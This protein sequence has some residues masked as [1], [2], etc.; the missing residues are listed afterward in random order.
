MATKSIVC[1]KLFT[2]NITAKGWVCKWEN[3]LYP[4]LLKVATL[5]FVKVWYCHLHWI[6]CI[7]W[8][9][10]RYWC[11]APNCLD[12]D[13]FWERIWFKEVTKYFSVF[14]CL[15]FLQTKLISLTAVC[16]YFQRNGRVVSS[17]LIG[18]QCD[19]TW[20]ILIPDDC[21]G[22]F[23]QSSEGKDFISIIKK[24]LSCVSW[25]VWDHNHI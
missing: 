18:F 13:V 21:S 1:C 3:I 9:S 2:C 23:S 22:V 4:V 11:V 7:C 6:T 15:S 19:I 5:L 25:I 17:S 24:S 20:Y 12:K 14:V 8:T 16:R 10:C